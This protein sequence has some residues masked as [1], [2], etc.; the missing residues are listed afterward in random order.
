LP[1][2]KA[3]DEHKPGKPLVPN[4]YGIYY[5]LACVCFWFMLVFFEI[6]GRPALLMATSVLFGSTMGLFDDLADLK[7][8]YKAVLPV[9][10]AL[11]YVVLG[12]TERTTV[13]IFGGSINLGGAFLLLLVPLMVTITT[14]SYNQL[15]GLNGLEAGSGLVVLCGVA[16]VSSDWILLVFPILV[17]AL[18]TYLSFKGRAFIGNVGSFSVGLTLA[19]ASIID[20]LKLMLL[21]CMLPFFANSILIL[22]SNYILHDRAVTLMDNEG[23]LYSDKVR[24]FRT[25]IVRHRH[26]SEKQAVII[27]YLVILFFVA[28]G[29]LV[30][31]L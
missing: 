2:P 17:L 25:L 5:A 16:F 10:A 3:V 11:P 26:M 19:V 20:N 31:M 24:S 8:R 27:I 21:I 23:K 4:G 14:N 7:W 22:Y 13:S 1:F 15:G 30:E 28:V 18:L 29:A 12:P 9:F 6:R